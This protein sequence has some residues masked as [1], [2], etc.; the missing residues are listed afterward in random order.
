[1]TE[2]EALAALKAM[3]DIEFDEVLSRTPA[4]TQLLVR[5]GMADWR[6]VMP[7]WYCKFGVENESLS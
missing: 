5:A 4:R 3:P 1:M 7:K 2:D 6:E